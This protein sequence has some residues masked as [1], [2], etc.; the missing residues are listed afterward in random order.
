MNNLVVKNV[1]F[2]GTELLAIQEKENGKIYVG[3]NSVLRNLGFDDKQI[4][5]RRDKWNADRV[6]NRGTQKFSGTLLNAGTSKDV[7]CIE[8]KK[9]PLALAKLEITPKMEKD[10]P[11][12]AAKLE[13]YQ[14][15]CAGVLAEAF[16]PKEIL[17]EQLSPELQMFGKLYEVVARQELKQKE[18]EAEL[19]RLDDKIDSFK[20]VVALNP[21]DWRKDTGKIINKIAQNLGGYEHIKAI[22]EESYRLLEQ[23]MGV[24]LNIRLTNKKKTMSLN[25]VC[26]SKIDKLNQL[27]VIADD[28][29]LIEGYIAIIKDM[30]IKYG[31]ADWEVA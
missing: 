6:L 10:M 26:K 15:K 9:L 2:C 19:S 27:D 25:G 17:S 16:L 20:E 14:D 23:R 21:N 8:V 7:W 11:E 18:Q 30:A 22:R 24:A 1:P 31:I 28:K 12:L 3:I 5:Y 4:E 29:K 13:E